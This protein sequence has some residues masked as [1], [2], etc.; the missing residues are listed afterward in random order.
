[1]RRKKAWKA[2]ALVFFFGGLGLFYCGLWVGLAGVAAWCV[3]LALVGNFAPQTSFVPA[4]FAANAVFI[5]P[6]VW[7]VKRHNRQVP[8]NALP[9]PKPTPAQELRKAAKYAVGL[10]VLD[11][12]LLDQGILSALFL[13]VLICAIPVVA[14]YSAVRKRWPEFRQRMATIGIYAAA[15]L[16]AIGAVYLNNAMAA[17]RAVRLGEACREFHTKYNRYPASLQELAPEFIAGV[18]AAK[19]TFMNSDFFYMKSDTDPEIYYVEV[20]PFGRRFYHVKSG[21]WGYLD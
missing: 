3:A 19:Y 9:L 20:P 17:R 14:L 8:A 13:V 12:F 18:P 5:W 4:V 7:L 11:A 16:A 10:F 6:A 21:S 1:M 2:T 15:C